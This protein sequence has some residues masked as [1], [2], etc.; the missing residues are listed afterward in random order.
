MAEN[1]LHPAAPLTHS[2]GLAGRDA[3][4]AT[5]RQAWGGRADLL[6]AGASALEFLTSSP[7]FIGTFVSS[8]PRQ[9]QRGAFVS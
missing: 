7:S 3:A 6:P 4:A 2:R 9:S 8:A 1:P 5:V